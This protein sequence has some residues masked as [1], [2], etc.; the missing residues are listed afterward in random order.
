MDINF[1]DKSIEEF[2]L[3][4]LEERQSLLE[5]LTATQNR[6]SQILLKARAWRQEIIRLGGKDPGPP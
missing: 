5:N 3:N 1:G 2:I 4:L 6:S